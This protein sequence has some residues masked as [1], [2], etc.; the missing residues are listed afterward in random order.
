MS[1]SFRNPLFVRHATL[2]VGGTVT[3]FGHRHFRQNGY[4]ACITL[5]P[6]DA[7]WKF[8]AIEVLGEKRLR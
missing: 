1:T 5:V 3:H 6:V 4:D 7:S 8:H 2:T